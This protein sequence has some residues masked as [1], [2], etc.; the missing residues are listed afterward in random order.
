MVIITSLNML[1]LLLITVKLAKM[2]TM[3]VQ[4]LGIQ[5]TNAVMMA[6]IMLGII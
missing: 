5:I 1:L 6:R 3:V 4:I 2:K